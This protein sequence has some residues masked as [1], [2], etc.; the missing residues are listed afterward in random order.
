MRQR[1][2]SVGKSAGAGDKKSPSGAGQ[3]KGHITEAGNI[4]D[5]A[6]QHDYPPYSDF[7]GWRLSDSGLA[8]KRIQRV[9]RAKENA[10]QS[11]AG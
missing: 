3:V 6:R 11:A 10:R 2:A 4:P 9:A 8:T 7:E 1:G 5:S